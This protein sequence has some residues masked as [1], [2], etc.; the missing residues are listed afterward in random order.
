MIRF[1]ADSDID[2]VIEIWSAVFKDDR[3]DIEKF[4]SVIGINNA[5]GY[6]FENTLVSFYFLIDSTVYVDSHEYT[7]KYL[8]AAC[9]DK[10]YR[11][12]GFMGELLHFLSSNNREIGTD[13]I[14]L[15]PAQDS[16]FAYYRR[17]GFFDFLYAKHTD[18]PCSINLKGFD[19]MSFKEPILSYAEEMTSDE[20]KLNLAPVSIPG[21][22]SQKCVGMALALS[23]S[24]K[25]ISD[26]KVFFNLFME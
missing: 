12:R 24:A 10:K 14:A 18:I 8:Y 22:A 2:R 26:K 11:G 16:L 15:V 5:I 21:C 1:L 25:A 17:F 3:G 4:I 7:C 6:F 13:L 20:Y 23:E 19:R 9:T